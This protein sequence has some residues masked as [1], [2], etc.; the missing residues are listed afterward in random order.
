MKEENKAIEKMA[1]RVLD[2]YEA[3]HNKD[4]QK[5]KQLLEPLRSLLHQDDRPNVT[6]LAYLAISQIG[7]KDVDNFLNTYEELKR[8]K[9]KNDKEKALQTRVDEMFHELMEALKDQDI[10]K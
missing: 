8:N 6:F 1:K 9:P 10:G 3:I 4:F 7:S 5:G 2:G